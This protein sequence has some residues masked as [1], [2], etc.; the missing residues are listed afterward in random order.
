MSTPQY[1]TG[2]ALRVGDTISVWWKPGQDT[3]INL[4]PYEPPVT[5]DLPPGRYQVAV[6]ALNTMGMTIEPGQTY[7]VTNRSSN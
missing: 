6:F 3:I 1:I 2:D 7:E 4:I 5:M